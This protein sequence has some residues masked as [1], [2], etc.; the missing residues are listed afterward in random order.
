MKESAES[1]SFTSVRKEHRGIQKA[2][3]YEIVSLEELQGKFRKEFG[4]L[5][6]SQIFQSKGLSLSYVLENE[7]M[8]VGEITAKFKEELDSFEELDDFFEKYSFK[9]LDVLLGAGVLT[10]GQR[11]ELAR[12]HK[13]KKKCIND[14]KSD[15]LKL[16]SR[17]AGRSERILKDLDSR[18]ASLKKDPKV[19]DMDYSL[20][21][22]LEK[23]KGASLSISQVEELQRLEREKLRV[24][25]AKVGFVLQSN[26]TKEKED[27][28]LKYSNKEV[29][30]DSQFEQFKLEFESFN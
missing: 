22:G 23:G 14:C 12:L 11:D 15:L 18:I 6:L 2:L 16:D 27:L 29:E 21:D 13:E 9:D 10:Q 17:L 1:M 20:D 28:Q 7:L 8:P 4:A 24:K 25:N 30:I 26:Y 5:Q 19:V 3:Q